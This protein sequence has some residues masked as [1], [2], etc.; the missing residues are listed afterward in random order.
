M[1]PAHVWADDLTGAAEFAR[2][3]QA[4]TGRD[5]HVRLGRPGASPPPEGMD[6]DTVWDLDVRHHDDT[7][8]RDAVTA[9]LAG[10][11]PVATP[12]L[13]LDSRLRGPVRAYLAAL[14]TSGRPV[15]LC[16]ANPALGRLTVAGRHGDADDAATEPVTLTE[17]GSGLAHRHLGRAEYDE[18]PGL[19]SGPDPILLTA[20]VS[21]T[22]DLDRL[23]AACVGHPRAVFAGSAAFLGALARTPS[24]PEADAGTPVATSTAPAG[25]PPKAPGTAAPG[26]GA[27]GPVTV[28]SLLAVLGTGEPISRVQVEAL[29]SRDPVT[30][31]VLPTEGTD[32]DAVAAAVHRARAGLARGEH[33]VLTLPST[34]AG[35]AARRDRAGMASLAAACAAT[36][37]GAPPEV[38]LFLSGGHTARLV[39]EQL[40]L[41]DLRT[42]PSAVETVAQLYAPDGRTIWT[43]PGSYGG[44]SDLLD[45]LEPTRLLPL[46]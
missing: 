3:W 33:V 18:L 32:R 23:A 6:A 28:R 5:V 42:T 2:L 31:I 27:T 19:L 16:P 41:R 29:S 43:K 40:G 26:L 24:E 11:T 22:A 21:T 34:A 35:A 17:L 25:H 13:K 30:Q 37:A 12:F 15:V 8:A 36:L 7:A 46:P 38:G 14:L 39:L 20:D 45:L 4:S 10:P 9:L 44:P 1:R